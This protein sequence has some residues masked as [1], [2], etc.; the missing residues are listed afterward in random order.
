MA[1]QANTQNIASQIVR[2]PKFSLEE[3]KAICEAYVV[4]TLDPI[5]GI[6]QP[7]HTLWGNI[8]TNFCQ[9]TGNPKD[10]DASGLSH[11]FGAISKDMNSWVALMM[12]MKQKRGSG[13]T[14]V[15]VGSCTYILMEWNGCD[16][17]K[18]KLRKAA[19]DAAQSSI[20]VDFKLQDYFEKQEKNDVDKLVERKKMATE[21]KKGCKEVEKNIFNAHMR[22]IVEMDTSKM[23]RAQLKF[24]QDKFNTIQVHKAQERPPPTKGYSSEEEEVHEEDIDY[25]ITLS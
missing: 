14:V 6:Q 4:L 22:G 8:F 9:E 24:W 10:R 3:D 5:N 16:K 25:A 17:S 19:Q 2:G 15:D 7:H 18:K 1:S 21:M 20:S 11:R 23:N 13:D 12:Q